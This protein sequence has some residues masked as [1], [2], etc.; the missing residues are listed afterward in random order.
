MNTRQVNIGIIG[1]G[2]M[3]KLH[4]AAYALAP[5][6]FSPA[7]F[8]PVRKLLCD[9]DLDFARHSAD[10]YQW[11]E[12][13]SD[14]RELVLRDDI[15]VVDICTPNAF[16]KDIAIAAA[17]A[18]KMIYCE[19]PL[20][21]TAA[22]AAEMLAA[23]RRN[24]VRTAVAFNKR[25]FPAVVYARKLVDEGFI[26][27]P[28]AFRGVFQSSF[29]LD[30]NVPAS[31][32]FQKKIAGTGVMGDLGSHIIDVCR[33]LIGE[34]DEVIGSSE[35]L[36]AERPRAEGARGIFAEQNVRSDSVPVD[37][38]DGCWFLARMSNGAKAT[39]EVTRLSSGKHDGLGFEL[40]G[41][42]GSIRWD[43]Q[44]AMEIAI[45]SEADAA[46]RRGFKTVE[47]GGPH[48]YG[49]VLWEVPGFGIGISDI[50]SLEIHDFIHAAL[51]GIPYQPDF[52]DGLQ[53][54]RIC[55]AVM[56]SIETRRWTKVSSSAE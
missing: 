50:K 17:E 51:E 9:I 37:V 30:P 21:L 13:T 19:K 56:E 29:A 16:H 1:G 27:R 4:S 2:S 44:R 55:D 5:L 12:V 7:H 10:R 35:I 22:D 40:W 25:R 20:A 26:G 41:T 31:W 6:Y 23:A 24:G 8:I 48:P 28:L 38:E 33:Y 3:C 54:C 46:D 14:W 39:F 32:R 43:Q 47:M 52:H 34:F 42:E 18:G 53:V 11:Q 45:C 49:N 15:D 36:F